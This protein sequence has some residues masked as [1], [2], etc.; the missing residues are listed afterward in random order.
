MEI[1]VLLKEEVEDQIAELSEMKMGSDE[2]K[3]AVDGV[4]KLTERLIELEKM[5]F[6]Q[7]EREQTRLFE[8]SEREQ[9][10]LTDIEFRTQ[11]RDDEQKD[12]LIKN[13]LTGASLVTG[14][15]LTVWGT[16]KTFKFEETGTVTTIMGR[17]FINKLLPGKK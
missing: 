13:C 8:Q 9:N 1:K 11:E 17:G 6:E 5:E 15:G 3:T 4:S 14:I 16:L 12:R 2:Y 10:R 7:S